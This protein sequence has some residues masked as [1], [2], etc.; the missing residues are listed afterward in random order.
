[1]TFFSSDW[2]RSI[3]R[4]EVHG[5]YRRWRRLV[6]AYDGDRMLVGEVV[7]SDPARVADYVR[8]DELH[9]AFNFTF[10]F[11]DWDPGS[12]RSAVDRTLAAFAPVGATATWVLENHDVTRLPTRY[13][14]GETGLDR[15]R[16][17]LLLLLALPG[18]VF[19]YAGQE[20]GLEEA[21]LAD[22]ERQDP[23]FAR[24]GGERLGRD[25]CRVPL[26]WSTEL[27]GFGFTAGVPWLPIPEVWANACVDA[28]DADEASTLALAR[29]ALAARR[30]SAALRE[31]SFV[32]LPG[33]AE[34]LVFERRAGD[35]AVVC[36]VNLGDAPLPLPR[37]ELVLASAGLDAGAVPPNAAAWVASGLPAV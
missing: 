19:L 30:A 7:F 8:P 10:L 22:E 28:Q 11:E 2:R 34:A 4:P 13:G 12:L 6:D 24:T 31:G 20:L 27:P 29:A 1:V 26:P 21:D 15:A 3:D 14:G 33:P 25:G 23:I 32:W 37:G 36:A 35:G 17:A 16:A 18:A 5:L 9:L